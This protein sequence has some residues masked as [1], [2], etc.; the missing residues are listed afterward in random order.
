MGP[1]PGAHFHL[2]LERPKAPELDKPQRMSHERGITRKPVVSLSFIHSFI[3][4]GERVSLLEQDGQETEPPSGYK[5]KVKLKNTGSCH[6]NFS[7]SWDMGRRRPASY[8]LVLDGRKG[9]KEGRKGRL[10]VVH[11][12]TFS[13]GLT[14][15][16][17][18]CC[19]SRPQ[20]YSL[21]APGCVADTGQR[22]DV[23]LG[24][25]PLHAPLSQ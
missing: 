21:P 12:H 8:F 9:G 20:V 14:A 17:H 25:N 2:P 24:S 23:N 18:K 22:Q 10:Y 11:T 19:C 7:M 1:A 6:L 4:S 16:R 3:H 15:A 13:S 5:T